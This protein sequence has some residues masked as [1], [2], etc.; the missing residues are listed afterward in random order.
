[1]GI[2]VVI[3]DYPC[4]DIYPNGSVFSHKSNRFLKPIVHANGY[5]FVELFNEFGSKIKSIHRLVAEAFLPNPNNYPCV[6]HKD[7]NPLNNN[8]DNLEWCTHKYNSNYGTCKKRRVNNTDYTKP[9][10][11]ELAHTNSMRMRKA[12]VQ[13]DLNGTELNVFES[14]TEAFRVTGIRHITEV[15]KGSKVRKTA[16][17][18]IWKYFEKGCDDLS[19]SL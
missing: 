16:G 18:Y 8:A 14:A 15:C 13:C 19:V 17:G 7:E 10:Y 3:A 12:V 6:N 1:M 5:A 9:I 2:P 4:Y 11:K